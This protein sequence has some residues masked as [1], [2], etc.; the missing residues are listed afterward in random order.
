MAKEKPAPQAKGNT[1]TVTLTHL[2][3]DLARATGLPMS[4]A[5]DLLA[6]LNDRMIEALLQGK[7]LQIRGVGTIRCVLGKAR[8]GRNPRT[9]ETISIPARNT[10][11]FKPAT[12]LARQIRDLP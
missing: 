12:D 4:T 2:A 1:E 10:L 3:E 11:R 9:G 8:A 7:N 6:I 5:R